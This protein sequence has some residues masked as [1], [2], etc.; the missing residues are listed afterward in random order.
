M[1]LQRFLILVFAAALTAG[2]SSAISLVTFQLLG[3]TGGGSQF[4]A[5]TIDGTL[6]G[7]STQQGASSLYYGSANE[8]DGWHS[9]EIDYTNNSGPSGL[10]LLVNSGWA[11]AGNLASY[12]A[13]GNVING[14]QGIFLT[15]QGATVTTVYGDGEGPYIH[16]TGGSAPWSGTYN[17]YTF[18]PTS[19]FQEQLIGYIYLGAGTPS[20]STVPVQTQTPPPTGGDGG[21]GDT[22]GTGGD[23]SGA[24]PEPAGWWLMAAAPLMLFSKLR[25]NRVNVRP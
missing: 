9:I 2:T 11:A 18:T 23:D 14:L 4:G 5:L 7:S 1:K 10:T 21:G 6:L 20:L 25:L 8:T 19:T 3:N 16:Y 13:G 15:L 17:S 12:D 22:G 24:A